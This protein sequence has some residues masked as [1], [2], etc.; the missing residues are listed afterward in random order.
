M[1][2]AKVAIGVVSVIVAVGSVILAATRISAETPTLEHCADIAQPVYQQPNY[3]NAQPVYNSYNNPQ[4]TFNRYVCNP[5]MNVRPVYSQVPTFNQPIYNQP[6]NVAP[7][8]VNPKYL[9]GYYAYPTSDPWPSAMDVLKQPQQQVNQNPPF[10]RQTPVYYRPNYDQDSRRYSNNIPSSNQYSPF[11]KL[12]NSYGQCN[13]NC[14]QIPNNGYNQY[15][16]NTYYS[17]Y[18][19]PYYE[20]NRYRYSSPNTGYQYNSGNIYNQQY[21]SNSNGMSSIPGVRCNVYE[22]NILESDNIVNPFDNIPGDDNIERCDDFKRDP[23]VVD[24][25]IQKTEEPIA[26]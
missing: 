19:Y 1:N 22:H 4:P 18:D 2:F 10:N 5:M 8:Y 6:M 15:V 25:F 20:H 7:M 24:I 17:G 16:N 9:P 3:D 21:P 26:L 14:N 23:G 11:D 12:I 13:I